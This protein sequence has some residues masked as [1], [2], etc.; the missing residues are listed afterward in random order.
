MAELEIWKSVKGYEGLYEI[1]NLGQVRSLH[2]KGTGKKGGL[3]S[4]HLCHK[5]YLVS[6]LSK[7]SKLQHIKIHRLVA[8]AFVEKTHYEQ[9]QVDHINGVKTDN[10][11]SNLRWVTSQQN[12]MNRG[13]QKSNT[14]GHKGVYFNKKL[15]K[16]CVQ[17]NY[18][19]KRI[20]GGLFS[21]FEEAVAKRKELEAQYFGDYARQ[22]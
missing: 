2:N 4:Y 9:N 18:Q 7:E 12:C 6:N 14:S 10:R 13:V 21:G 8:E 5:G 1:S 15:V 22:E 3:L 16:W 17:I 19:N 11:A 20:Y